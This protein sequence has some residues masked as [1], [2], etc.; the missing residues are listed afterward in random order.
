MRRPAELRRRYHEIR[1]A[2][3]RRR[4]E[5]LG[6]TLPG[7]RDRAHR[8]PLAV[9]C[10][11]TA[12]AGAVVAVA[13][14]GEPG[15]HQL[16][17]LALVLLWVVQWIVLRVVT[18]GISES[19]SLVL[20]EREKALRDRTTRYGFITAMTLNGA[21]CGAL[22][23]LDGR[24][25]TAAHLAAVIASVTLLSSTVPVG[26]LAWTLPDDDPADLLDEVDTAP[27]VAATARDV[28]PEPTT[29]SSI[30]PSRD[31][32]TTQTVPTSEN[33][34]RAD[35]GA[36]RIGNTASPPAATP[37]RDNRTT[38]DGGGRR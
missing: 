6:R 23:S 3:H 9:A 35:D 14:G 30:L 29:T 21:I 32:P 27:G 31:T 22:G 18:S 17:W 38:P 1:V 12:L 10:G 26:V 11:A 37:E 24:E 4:L 34:P 5:R 15:S 8:R 25:V 33:P 13:S 2:A 36:A 20:D 28:T 19:S 7:W 16:L